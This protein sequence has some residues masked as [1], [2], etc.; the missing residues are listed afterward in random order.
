M[1]LMFVCLLI[2]PI[3]V[4][5]QS[6]DTNEVVAHSGRF[7]NGK[8][9]TFDHPPI[10][11]FKTA[12]HFEPDAAW[13][14]HARLGALRIPGCSASFVSPH[15][16]V[17]TNHHC[18]RGPASQV[19]KPGENIL[20]NGFYAR[21][22][23]EERKPDG[24]YADQLVKITDVTDEVYK[25]LEGQE[26]DAEK[27]AARRQAV[28]DITKRMI[29]EAGGEAKG[30]HVEV[31]SLYNGAQYS[32]YTFHRYSDVRLVMAPEL[33]MGYFGGDSDNFTYPRYALDM[34]MFR[35]YGDNGKPLKT[36]NYF[37][38]STT[39]TTDG[40]A[41]FVIGNPGSTTRLQTV[42]QLKFR[43]DVREKAILDLINSRVA[44]LQASLD[45]STDAADQAE[46]RNQ[47]FGLMNAQKLYTGRV[48]GL[49]DPYI[50]ARR[51]DDEKK[52]RAA[53][54]ADS[55]LAA[56]Y[57]GLHE[58]M[59]AVQ[60]EKSKY[61]PEFSS[62]LA[63]QPTSGLASATFRRALLANA[64]LSMKAQGANEQAL[65]G[66]K[67]QFEGIGDLA[68]EVEKGFLTARLSEFM[69]AFGKDEAMIR[70]IFSLASKVPA[71]AESSPIRPLRT[72]DALAEDVVAN[73][74][75]SDS[76]RANRAIADGT[77]STDDPAIKLA[78]AI[79]PRVQAFQSA[80]AGLNAQQQ[81][82]AGALGRAR[83][84][85]YGTDIPPDATF[86]LRIA[87]G[88][89]K[90]YAYNGTQAP[91]HTTFYGL[92]E[93]FYA[94]GAGTEWDLPERW[95]TPPKSFDMSTPLDFVSTADII[96][97]N[98]GSPMV[99]KKLELVGLI[100]DGNIESLTGD[101]IYLTDQQR[102]VAVDSRGILEAL[103]KIY[104]ADRLV[105]ELTT[106]KMV[107][108]EEAADRER[109]SRGR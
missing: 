55:I 100:F 84:A 69:R 47:I 10:D 44:V 38:W 108:T 62:F 19:R 48:K 82:I 83:F 36:D 37:K 102:A 64:Y 66:L 109:A 105:L 27:S 80:F 58:K 6:T 24:F 65:D 40:D 11:Y 101:Y 31:I 51:A 53:I 85:V 81:E 13:F 63:M 70:A 56:Q 2:L 3:R 5:A 104:D 35:V 42:S 73:S 68:P 22:L 76:V 29:E 78:E 30:A 4:L 98:S 45:A 34:T 50:I 87:D 52:F 106:G 12:Y 9:W 26:T 72:P 21:S 79:A 67:K 107:D 28:Q 59:A 92:Y 25:A 1:A 71:G 32:A 33:Q 74:V 43:R 7:D 20:D 57:G 97:G 23:D 60:H 61:A 89:V 95:R 8:M 41:V 90:G 86:S 88:V 54:M 15:G 14:E 17:L 39:G 99:N 75:L 16:L 77:L 93:R 91:S 94:H 49:K 46:M 103:D 18:G 96:G